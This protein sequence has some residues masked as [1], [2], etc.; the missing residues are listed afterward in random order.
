MVPCFRHLRQ[1][2]KR[3]G[4]FAMLSLP[5]TWF[6]LGSAWFQGVLCG[7]LY[8][9]RPG[10]PR[11]GDPPN[12]RVREARFREARVS[13]AR[14]REARVRE[15]RVCE[16]RVREAR[17]CEARVRATS[18]LAFTFGPSPVN[19]CVI[20]TVLPQICKQLASV[21]NCRHGNE[22]EQSS[23]IRNAS[24]TRNNPNPRACARS[25]QQPLAQ[26]IGSSTFRQHARLKRVVA[27]RE[28]RV[29]FPA[30]SSEGSAQFRRPKSNDCR[31]V[32]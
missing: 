23:Y 29:S 25:T 18:R 22:E 20:I 28:D 13:E 3:R 31:T 9:P 27:W 4:P 7:F 32:L 17:V 10:D 21:S 24:A 1:V 2:A 16:A 14:V 15:A 8:N 26:G 11:P 12:R 19:K 6:L 5:R 30:R